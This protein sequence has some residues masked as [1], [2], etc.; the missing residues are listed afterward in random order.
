MHEIFLL[1]QK[2]LYIRKSKH[3]EQLDRLEFYSCHEHEFVDNI[4]E[5]L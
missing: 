4:C 2:A 3:H 5:Y 1:S